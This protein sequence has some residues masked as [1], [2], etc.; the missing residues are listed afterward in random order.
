MKVP[1]LLMVYVIY[2][3]ENPNLKWITRGTPIWLSIHGGSPVDVTVGLQHRLATSK[4]FLL[5]MVQHPT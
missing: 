5:A 1:I 4:C 3:M 2:V